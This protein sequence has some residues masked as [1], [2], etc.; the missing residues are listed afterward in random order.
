MNPAYLVAGVLA[1]MGAAIHGGVGEALVVRKIDPEVLPRSRWGGGRTTIRF[2]R[3]SWHMVTLT[4]AAFGL[5]LSVCSARE[6]SLAC[7]GAGTLVAG[8]STAFAALV[9]AVPLIARSPRALIRHPAPILLSAVA[10][11]AWLGRP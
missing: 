3:A 1:L 10:L 11:L 8:T 7:A 5:S 9:I 6:G 4:F 2:I